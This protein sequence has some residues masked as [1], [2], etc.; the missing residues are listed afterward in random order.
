MI[1]KKSRFLLLLF[2]LIMIF[3]LQSSDVT[4][5]MNE[6]TLVYKGKDYVI[7]LIFHNETNIS[8]NASLNVTEFYEG[9]NE[10]Q[11]YYSQTTQY[12]KENMDNEVSYVRFF[13][14]SILDGNEEIEP[15]NSVDV[16]IQYENN[17]EIPLE[18][19]SVIHFVEDGSKE[20]IDVDNSQIQGEVTQISFEQESFSVIGMIIFGGVNSTEK[21]I[22]SEVISDTNLIKIEKEWSDG[23]SAHE[24]DTVTISLYEIN[25]DEWIKINETKLSS[26][27]K[28]KGIFSE[29]NKDKTY[30][31]RETKVVSENQD[32]TDSY[33]SEIK[34]TSRKEWCMKAENSFSD[35]DEILLIFN[36]GKNRLMRK[37]GN[38]DEMNLRAT[39]I[40]MEKEDGLGNYYKS[41]VDVYYIWNTIWNEEYNAWELYNESGSAYLT[42]IYNAEDDSYV[43]ITS[44]EKKE[45]SFLT[46]ENGLL[47]ATV[48]GVTKYIG[49]VSGN[50]PYAGVDKND[51]NITN[52]SILKYQVFNP[53]EYVITNIKNATVDEQ[54][55][56][57]DVITEKTID[58]LG[59]KQDNE[60]TDVDDGK[61]SDKV[62]GDLYR[63]NLNVKMQTDVTGLDLLMV[64]DVS[65]SMKD[66]KDSLDENGNYIFRSE[67]L[68]Q[69]LNQFVPEF[70]PENTKNRLAVVAFENQSMILQ[71]WTQD[72]REVLDK[73][74]YESEGELPLYNGEGTNYEGALIRAHEALSRRG[75]S[76]NAKAM[77][78]LSD[79]EPTVYLKGNDDLEKGNVSINLGESNLG[80]EGIEGT[81]P[82]GLYEIW[83]E[84]DNSNKHDVVRSSEEAVESF[85]K[86]NPEIM[87][88]T[89]AFNT[90]IT[91]SLKNLATDQKFITQIKN[92]SPIELIEA[93]ELI[94]K[95]TPQEIVITDE[96]SKN[97]EL[98]E[99]EPD[100][101]ASVENESGKI[102]ELSDS[103]I[104]FEYKDKV[105]VMIF[106][107]DYEVKNGYTYSFSF[108]VQNSQKAYDQYADSKGKYFVLGDDK[109]DYKN[110][111]TS[112]LK[113]GFYSN[114]ENTK[115]TYSMN[116]ALVEKKFRKP[117]VQ[118]DDGSLLI[119]KVDR[120]NNIISTGAE[121]VLYRKE[122]GNL[123]VV[124][125]GKTDENGELLFEHL[126]LSVF[127]KGYKYYLV[128]EKAP[129]GYTKLGSPVEISLFKE[130]VAVDSD[131]SL[132]NTEQI[133]LSD[134]SKIGQVIVQN[135]EEMIIPVT[136]GNGKNIFYMIGILILTGGII[137]KKKSF[138]KILMMLMTFVMAFQMLTATAFAINASDRGNITV[139]GV[140]N[141]IGISAYRLMDIS[142]DYNVQ[143]PKNP[144]YMWT[145]E[146]AGW[147]SDHYSDFINVSNMNA[148]EEA[149]STAEDVLV[150]EFYDELAVAI[151]DGTVHPA[152]E[153]LVAEGD[154]VTIDNLSMGN[155]F[156][157]IEG[158]AKVYRPLTANVVPE[159]K[160]N[161]WVMSHPEVDAKSSEPTIK[162]TV[163]NGLDADNADIGDTL[164]FE[165]NAVIPVY[166]ENATA[167]RYVISDRLSDSLTLLDN[168][169]KVY[170]LNSGKVDELLENGYTKG[171]VR[172]ES[173]DNVSFSLEFDYD[174]IKGYESVRVTYDAVL[175]GNG[176]VG[177]AGNKN[178]AFLDYNN[179]PYTKASW[180]TDEDET[181][182]YTYGMK[183][184]KI[185][186]DTNE[187]LGGAEFTLSKAGTEILFVGAD[188]N[189]RVAEANENGS[190]I[191]I[192]NGEGNLILN[193]LDADEYVLTEV[194]A[195][196]GYVK[197]QNPIDITITD[198]DMNGKVEADGKELVDGYMPVTVKNDK[199]FTLPVTGG[200]GTTLFTLIGCGFV[201]AGVLMI[202]VYYRNNKKSK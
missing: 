112:S 37:S 160:N 63:L 105:V 138:S 56:N 202:V 152:S 54:E 190:S 171:N 19:I 96:L 57:V 166:P 1:L 129:D 50:G 179:N 4:A 26:K 15:D 139:N 83:I 43:W 195:P 91:E 14:I 175:N 44:R 2:V 169:I 79:G 103:D 97:V 142:F 180:N 32:K 92:G 187:A 74:N 177:E 158:G 9:S 170:G 191:V 70:I 200:I 60:F 18:E 120:N 188:G 17:E 84:N 21:E 71:D 144:M 24:E 140:E 102:T 123:V 46:Y 124:E 174:V 194:K 108:N 110:N 55:I 45:G 181:T 122:S 35:G 156:L 145:S 119:K 143:Q 29:L 172:P 59:D 153:T 125:K 81:L 147:V 115:V 38:Y 176:V 33:Q 39:E 86:N 12:L 150:A 90:I 104:S 155:Y 184:S 3:I 148:V 69:A 131:N 58:Y 8:E 10:Y 157:L 76:N 151:K 134:G 22:N 135:E 165:L 114:G 113:E 65:S 64:I 126:R 118:V 192:V 27:S 162:K 161:T 182:V 47:C 168:S 34:N 93:M 198:G 85:K 40:V 94:T 101:Y 185:D 87:I 20:L 136:G 197:L 173:G 16:S 75:Y 25:N 137:M 107:K 11:E 78:F 127:D 196:N 186:E 146:V 95:F 48:N 189:Y 77:I 41:N 51:S 121:F 23:A 80:N 89:I 130:N 13:D 193:G 68:R 201:A 73:V 36:D 7:E 52:F 132:V 88:G 62:L 159:W 106:K 183:I 66:N 30:G 141:G 72:A 154:V 117:V 61:L 100:F 82:A 31:I 167:K 133:I 99:D 98:Y 178:H 149:F 53:G 28:W 42:L 67:A 128:E 111:E 164:S 5:E 109:T 163:T 199:G 49:N 6:K 116:G